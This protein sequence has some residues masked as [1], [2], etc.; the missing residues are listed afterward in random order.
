M[1]ID[2]N[3]LIPK[4]VYENI[5][6]YG[7]IHNNKTDWYVSL[8]I[9]F[10]YI[11]DVFNPYKPEKITTTCNKVFQIAYTKKYGFERR[12]FDRAMVQCPY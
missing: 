6:S 11:A 2:F 9:P 1:R 12:V 10:N 7:R 8:R 4:E 5:F 3:K